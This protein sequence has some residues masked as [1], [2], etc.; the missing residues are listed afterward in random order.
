MTITTLGEKKTPF[1]CLFNSSNVKA[2]V[3]HGDVKGW[4]FGFNGNTINTGMF[5]F[6]LYFFLLFSY[7]FTKRWSQWIKWCSQSGMQTL[8]E[9]N[10]DQECLHIL[11]V[12]TFTSTKTSLT[13]SSHSKNSELSGRINKYCPFLNINNTWCS[14][15]GAN[16]NIRSS[17]PKINIWKLEIKAAVASQGEMEDTVITTRD[18]L[19]G[20]P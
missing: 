12:S 1:T 4:C 9:I 19:S 13:P 10:D 3:T 2:A 18:T 14:V 20:I 16:P 8:K 11:N 7:M 5:S 6:L 15:V 17:V